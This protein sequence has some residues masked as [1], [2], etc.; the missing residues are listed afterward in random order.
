VKYL[1]NLASNRLDNN[2]LRLEDIIQLLIVN[3]VVVR[4]EVI[5]DIKDIIEVVKA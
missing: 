4:E 5:E 3:I 1:Y 2:I